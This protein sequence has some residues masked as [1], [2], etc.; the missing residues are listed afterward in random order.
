MN[1]EVKFWHLRN[2]KLFS[3]LDNKQIEDLC[4]V[5][6]FK[7]AQKGEIIYFSDQA[8][9]RIYFLKKGTIKIAEMDEK[10]NEIIKE[11]LQ[12]GD[13][14]GEMNLE[15]GSQ[16]PE[17][18]QAVSKV[19]EICSFKMEDFEKMLE[20][21]PSVALGYTKMIGFRFTNLKNKYSNL[22]FKDVK[23][24]L[25]AFL[26]DWAK[27]EGVTS[28][29]EVVLENYLTHKDLANLI[30]ASR[31]TVTELLNELITDQIL[32]YSRKVITIP[33]FSRLT[34]ITH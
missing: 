11:L 1:S 21:Y 5:L 23:S 17:F 3:V 6:R 27:K 28:G 8:D 10:G 14:F 19:V 9:K 15:H 2:H 18:A 33:D 29:K 20:S 7:T 34:S 16:T 30:C 31:Q 26:I 22:V 4:V 12:Q 24:R 13:L 32:V 25:V